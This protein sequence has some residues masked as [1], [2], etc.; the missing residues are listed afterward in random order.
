MGEVT[1]RERVSVIA[2]GNLLE[3]AESQSAAWLAAQG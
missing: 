3:L 2:L 1:Q